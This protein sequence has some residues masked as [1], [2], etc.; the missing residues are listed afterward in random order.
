MHQSIETPTPQVLGKG[1]GFDIDP[2]QKASRPRPPEAEIEIK[3]PNT[4][5][6]KF[7]TNQHLLWKEISNVLLWVCEECILVTGT[8]LIKDTFFC[9]TTG[10]KYG[11]ST[12]YCS[13]PSD[14]KTVS[15]TFKVKLTLL[16]GTYLYSIYESISPWGALKPGFH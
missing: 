12:H 9:S 5:G 3:C 8:M 4:W 13:R 7:K 6:K 10:I 14:H 2:G 15:A 11:Q 16:G 1:R